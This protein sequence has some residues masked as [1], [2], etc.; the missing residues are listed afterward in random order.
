[1]PRSRRRRSRSKSPRAMRRKLRMNEFYC[2][3][4]RKPVTVPKDDICFKSVR[5]SKRDDIP[6]LSAY[7]KKHDCYLNKF[8]PVNRAD[9][10]ANKYGDCPSRRRR[11]RSPSRRRRRRRSR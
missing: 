4:L 10:M 8:I 9:Y 3:S 5:S 7:S 6:M 11:R 1:M 2:V